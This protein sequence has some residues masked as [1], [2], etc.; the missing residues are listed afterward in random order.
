MFKTLFSAEYVSRTKGSLTCLIICLPTSW[1]I[2]YLNEHVT[3][4]GE[5]KGKQ[6]FLWPLISGDCSA[7]HTHSGTR[8]ACHL[9]QRRRDIHNCCRTFNTGT[10]TACFDSLCLSQPAFEHPNFHMWGVCFNQM[11]HALQR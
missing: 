8:P 3:I 1:E 9:A 10:A 11:F 5:D 6:C 4:A 7:C 2:L